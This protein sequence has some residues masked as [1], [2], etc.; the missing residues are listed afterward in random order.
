MLGSYWLLIF[1]L[2]TVPCGLRTACTCTGPNNVVEAVQWYSELTGEFRV[3]TT[4]LAALDGLV[5]DLVEATSVP[6][7]AGLLGGVDPMDDEGLLGVQNPVFFLAPTDAAF[8]RLGITPASLPLLLQALATSAS[9]REA[10]R[11]VVKY[12]VVTPQAL[13]VPFQSLESMGEGNY[14]TLG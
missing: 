12:H 2:L 4:L 8:S 7:L 5:S 1:H 14:N 13:P 10:M 6:S 3:L 11:A 9:A